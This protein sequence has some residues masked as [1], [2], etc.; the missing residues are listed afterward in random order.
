VVSALERI[1]DNCGAS[2]L[3]IDHSGKIAR[4]GKT[5]VHGQNGLRGASSKMD[6]GRFGLWFR[7]LDSKGGP[8]K[9]EIL[10]AKTFRTRRAEPFKVTVD[11]PAFTLCEDDDVEDDLTD[12]VV[13]DVRA[14]L[15]TSQKK[16]RKRLKKDM[17]VVRQGFIDADEAGLIKYLGNKK[18]WVINE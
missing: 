4:Q 17:N 9:L 14:N 18:G 8:V 1:R 3:M 15:G 11:Y 16:T 6:N 2:N 7:S 13:E 12:V 10:N 5:D